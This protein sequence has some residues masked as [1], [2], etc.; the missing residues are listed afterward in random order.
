MR[1]RAVSRAECEINRGLSVPDPP[2]PL[3]ETR[4]FRHDVHRNPNN[5]TSSSCHP[6]RLHVGY[7]IVW[8]IRLR[9]VIGRFIAHEV[10]VSPGVVFIDISPDIQRLQGREDAEGAI[11]HGAGR[12]RG[13]EFSSAGNLGRIRCQSRNPTSGFADE[14]A[15][16]HKIS[17]SPECVTSAMIAIAA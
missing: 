1:L 17:E 4:S 13:Q 15:L 3:A 2:L 5:V 9:I 16:L 6:E 11:Y 12:A 14:T 8:R 7:R 10:A